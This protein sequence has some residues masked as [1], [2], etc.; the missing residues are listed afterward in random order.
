[1]SLGGNEFETVKTMPPIHESRCWIHDAP[2]DVREGCYFCVNADTMPALPSD[3]E[4]F[5]L[6]G[7]MFDA[8][9]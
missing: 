9:E 4:E 3:D 1:M 2:F 7:F 8:D 6:D 5:D